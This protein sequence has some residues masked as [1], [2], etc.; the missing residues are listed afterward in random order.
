MRRAVD[1][2]RSARGAVDILVNNAGWDRMEAFLDNTPE[3]LDKVID[4][5]LRGATPL[6][7]R[8]LDDMVARSSGKIVS[9]SSER[10]ASA[11]R[12]SV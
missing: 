12:R 4:V 8:V 9:I 10:R 6:L 5:N 11:A 3:F 2:L 7:S 1:E